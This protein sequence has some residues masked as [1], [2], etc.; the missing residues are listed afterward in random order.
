MTSIELLEMWIEE[1]FGVAGQREIVAAMLVHD[2]S[3]QVVIDF[4]IL[5][6]NNFGDSAITELK[7]LVR[8]EYVRQSK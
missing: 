6:F 7:E 1:E 3:I 8:K 5:L 2:S 4:S